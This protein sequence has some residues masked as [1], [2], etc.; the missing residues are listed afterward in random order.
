MLNW[1]L[2]KSENNFT[3]KFELENHTEPQE[4]NLPKNY[5]IYQVIID[6]INDLTAPSAVF[7]IGRKDGDCCGQV[8]RVLSVKGNNNGQ[9]DISWPSGK[10][11]HLYYRPTHY[12]QSEELKDLDRRLELIKVHNRRLAPDCLERVTEY[13]DIKEKR[14]EL[15]NNQPKVEYQLRFIGV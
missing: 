13:T 8:T 9:L 7:F 2:G 11:P 5:G 10:F 6:P 1:L 15:I 3:I 12:I 14:Q 4:L